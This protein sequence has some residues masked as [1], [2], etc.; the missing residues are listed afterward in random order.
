VDV[1]DRDGD[2]RRAADLLCDEV[3]VEGMGWVDGPVAGDVEVQVSAHGEARAARLE[4]GPG[5]AAVVHLAEPVRRV[6]PG[7][8]VVV[9]RGDEVL[10]GGTAA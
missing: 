7:Q 8:S 4:L 6:A 9:Y 1:R 5:V 2:G 3:A 10:G